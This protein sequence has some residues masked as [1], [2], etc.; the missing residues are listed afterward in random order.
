MPKYIID[1]TETLKKQITVNAPFKELA[2]DFVKAMYN[3][4]EI[5]LN[6][7]DFIESNIELVE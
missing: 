5:V 7:E 2:L 4:D 3:C 1:I 6:S